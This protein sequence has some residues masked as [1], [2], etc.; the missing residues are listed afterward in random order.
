MHEDKH[1]KMEKGFAS[2]EVA[3]NK[4]GISV[5]KKFKPYN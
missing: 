2:E 1:K 3:N 4:L 5:Q